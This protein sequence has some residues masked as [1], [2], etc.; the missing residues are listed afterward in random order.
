MPLA[1]AAFVLAH[2]LL[3]LAL[4]THRRQGD[5]DP[6]LVNV[7]HDYI[8]NDMLSEEMGRG[9]PLGGLVRSGAR[10]E[11]LE[12]LVIDLSKRGRAGR[13]SCWSGGTSRR[14]HR[15]PPPGK[16][17]ITE[18]LEKAGLLPPEEPPTAEAPLSVR[19]P[20]GDLIPGSAENVLEPEVSPEQRR[21]QRQEVRK[22][23]AKAL[24]LGALRAKMDESQKGQPV[25]DPERGEMLMKA[26]HTA[27]QPPWQLALQRWMDAV[28]PAGRTYAKAS[29]RGA[30][31]DDG[32][33]LCGRLREGLD[34]AHRP[35]HQRLDGAGAAE[36]AGHH[37]LVLRRGR[38]QR[39]P[40]PSVRRRGD[41]RRV[42]GAGAALGV[43]GR[44]LRRQQHEPR[45]WTPSPGT[46][47][48]SAVLVLTDGYINYP[49]AE[50]PY[51]VLWGV[52]RASTGYDATFRPPYGE[53][54][55]F[56]P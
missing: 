44:R 16:S 36:G 23:A 49:A 53:V 50:P 47:E 41:A 30:E 3:H 18:A 26:I 33:V 32:V 39:G 48:V 17:P 13:P 15:R 46:R 7:A 56:D 51:T 42:A 19:T 28:A 27:Y 54:L 12:K 10:G 29:R 21:K 35:G 6:Y 1:D 25:Q 37:R 5:A 34:A 55:F 43:Q 2:E 8:I 4:D 22:A 52:V 38:R 31:R 40:H 20:R 45:A 11:S 24:S 9:V 14:P